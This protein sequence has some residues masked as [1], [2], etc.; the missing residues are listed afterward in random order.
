[1]S[2]SDPTLP[3]NNAAPKKVFLLGLLAAVFAVNVIDVFVP[4]LLP[5]IAASF[6]LTSGTTSRIGAYSAL[7]GVAT[8]LA[9]SAFSIRLRYKT[10]LMA[11]VFCTI[12][13]SLGVFLAPNFLLAQVFYSLN[14][15][16]S[17]MVGVMAPTIIAELYPMAKKAVR[18]SWIMATAVLASLIGNPITGF[19]ANTGSVTSWKDSLL[20]FMVPAT[21]VCMLIVVFLV[22]SKPMSA[23]PGAK[24]EPFLNGY[25]QVLTNR[26][27]VA[28]LFNS[29]FANMFF[30]TAFFAPSFLKDVFAV[31]PGIRGLLPVVASSLIVVGMLTGGYLVNRVGR[32]R[33]LVASAIPAVVFS[34]VG[35]PLSML[36]PN[37]WVVVG[38]RFVSSFIG[39]F[40][41]VAGSNLALEQVPKFRGTMMSLSSAM[42]GTGGALGIFI[43]GTILNSIATSSFSY[44]VTMLTL[45]GLGLIG[46]SLILLFAKDP[47]RQSS[48]KLS[49]PMIEKP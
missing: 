11:G 25:K 31:S 40:P 27:A 24:K 47:V 41:L 26:S 29:F 4:L 10:L 44:S 18:I 6:G 28:C 21:T 3:Q 36:I 46:T 30:A 43:G 8:G 19:L 37:M 1:M 33:L 49:A 32:K 42:G 39:G 7:A 23:Y 13:C 22:P 15:V 45:G 16:G 5:E 38:L 48:T 20:W 2:M 35:Y 34:I 14:G 12:I 9:L 17:V